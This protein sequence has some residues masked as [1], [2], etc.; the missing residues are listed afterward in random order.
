MPSYGSLKCVYCVFCFFLDMIGEVV[1]KEDPKELIT[2]K[3]KE[4]KRLAVIL[5]DL[6]YVHS[7]L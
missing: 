4:T 5:E 3:G 1:G 2:S 7:T 6:E